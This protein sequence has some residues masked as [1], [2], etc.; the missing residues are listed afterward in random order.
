MGN[1]YDHITHENRVAISTLLRAGFSKAAVAKQLNIHRST[2]YREIDRNGIKS[3]GYLP[4]VAKRRVAER[5]SRCLKLNEDNELS[6]KVVKYLRESWSPEQ[7]AGFL[8]ME[9]GGSSLISHETIYRWIYSDFGKRNRYY[10]FLRRK[11]LWR[12]PRGSRKPRAII[13]GRVSIAERP[14]V[15]NQK[16]EFGHWEGDLMLFTQA[17][18]K[19]NLITLRERTSRFFVAILNPSKHAHETALRIIDYFAAGRQKAV[20][21]ITFDNGAEFFLHLEIVK[22]LSVSTFF[23]DPYKSWQKGSVENGNGVLR[24]ELPRTTAI[25]TMPQKE[26]DKIV[27]SINRRPMKCLGFKT[28]EAVFNENIRNL[29]GNVTT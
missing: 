6:K 16:S 20:S 19:F 25:N 8:K 4:I 23:C 17:G 28:P 29:S 14:A 5:K 22:Q 1:K 27:M 12:T 9:N 15:I 11:R 10:T 13:P 2:I 26:I 21:S 24:F 3:V 7:I 18:T